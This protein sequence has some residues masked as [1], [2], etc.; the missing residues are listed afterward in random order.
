[1]IR[2]I[3]AAGE[4]HPLSGYTNYHVT[5]KEDGLDALEFDLDV[6]LDDYQLIQNETKIEANDNPWLVKKIDD[7]RISCQLD[8]D[9]LKQTVYSMFTTGSQSLALTLAEHLP[10]EWTVEGGNVS[11]VSRTISFDVCTDYDIV[12]ACMKTFDVRFVWHILEKRL[13]VYNPSMMQP[14]GEYLTSELNLKGLSFKGETVNFATRLYGYG[15]DGVSVA[16]AMVDDGVGGKVK[17]GLPYV[18]DHS[19]SDK[20]VCAYWKDDRYTIPEHLLDALKVK[21]AN[22]A[23]PVVSYE[24][25]V[26]DLAKVDPN[27]TFLDFAMFKKVTLIDQKRKIRVIYQILEYDEWPDDPERNSVTLASV[28]G[29]IQDSL[30]HTIEESVAEAEKVLSGVSKDINE[31]INMATAMLTGAFGGH[32][33]SNGS[34]IFIMDTADPATA[35]VVWRWGINGIGKSSTGIDGPYTSSLTFDDTFTTNVI[36]A[37]VIRGEHI[38][39][40]SIKANQI[41]QEYTDGI[42]HQAVNMAEGKIT[43]EISKITNPEGTGKLD[44][45]AASLADDIRVVRET[46]NTKMDSNSVQI[47]IEKELAK[48]IDKVTTATGYTFDQEGLRITK[49]GKEMQTLITENGMKV[50]RDDRTVLTA[51]NVG[52]D[53]ANLH[54]TTYLII[55]ANSRLEN[56]GADRT[57]CFWIGR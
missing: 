27:Y 42:T 48:G 32:I 37:M 14:T 25:D 29:K 56:Y 31:R 49:T 19:Y 10:P 1:M 53:A 47:A 22:V 41:S 57:G 38:E 51:N 15:K 28:P 20:I 43:A 18:E 54:A 30:K 50:Q 9:F 12:M 7:D 35:K 6:G 55:G 5:H 24:C 33:H 4:H 23:V 34:E 40:H 39:A 8:F 3:D 45:T 17:Y 16:D 2:V 11:T 13:V 26:L 21:L 44:Q 52:V 46:V 36:N